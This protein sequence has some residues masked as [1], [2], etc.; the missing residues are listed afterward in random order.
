MRCRVRY[1]S[2]SLR[3]PLLRVFVR[4]T[5]RITRPRSG[6]DGAPVRPIVVNCYSIA[7]SRA[8]LILLEST[9]GAA[10]PIRKHELFLV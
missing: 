6:H 10:I 5:D 1:P 2:A 7:R 8:V 9:N 3:D 4:I